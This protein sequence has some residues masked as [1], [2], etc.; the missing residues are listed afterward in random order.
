MPMPLTTTLI[1]A[2]FLCAVLGAPI[3]ASVAIGFALMNEFI[4]FVVT[5]RVPGGR[6]DDGTY[7][8]PPARQRT[9]I[10]PQEEPD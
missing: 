3:G 6:P 2:A 4:R 7:V 10:G 5:L 8:L 1:A 9:P